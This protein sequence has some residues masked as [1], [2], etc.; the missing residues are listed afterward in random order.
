M[1]TP[2]PPPY[3]GFRDT[4]PHLTDLAVLMLMVVVIVTSILLYV[5]WMAGVVD[6]ADHTPPRTEPLSFPTTTSTVPTG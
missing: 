2:L 1:R 6:D 4:H 3:W 5:M